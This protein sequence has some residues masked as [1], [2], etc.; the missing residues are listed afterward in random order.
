MHDIEQQT[1]TFGEI[2]PGKKSNSDLTFRK[3]TDEDPNK[4]KYNQLRSLKHARIFPE[5]P[6]DDETLLRKMFSKIKP[7]WSMFQK[8]S[9]LQNQYTVQNLKTMKTK[10][11]K[12]E[13]VWKDI[14]LHKKIHK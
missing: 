3:K 2:D 14:E 4:T 6:Y 7:S 12:L 13:K 9:K 5:I 10:V 1:Q 11:D 8:H